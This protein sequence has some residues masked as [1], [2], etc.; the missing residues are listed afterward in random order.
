[1]PAGGAYPPFCEG[2]QTAWFVAGLQ[3]IFFLPNTL[4]LEL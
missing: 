3:Q 2:L 4:T 1:L